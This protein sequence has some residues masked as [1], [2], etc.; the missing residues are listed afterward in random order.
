M[1]IEL[2]NI[3]VE[4]T[5]QCNLDCS[6]CHNIWKAGGEPEKFVSSYREAIKTLKKL[7]RWS[8]VKHITFTG[9]EPLLSE[10]FSEV[11]Q[12]ARIRKKEVTVVSN[13]N[14]PY[15]ESYQ[16]LLKLGVS[17]FKI[18]VHSS[19]SGEHDKMTNVEGSW[20]KA[21][22]T[23][24][25]ITAAG[26]SVLPVIV[27]TRHNISSV[28]STL[29]FISES[30]G[31]K[32]VMINRFNIGG[33][34]IAEMKNII[35]TMQELRSAYETANRVAGALNLKISSNVCTPFCV[36]NPADYPNI[37]FSSCSTDRSKLP[38][39][40]DL[41]G[42]IRLCNHS[43]LVAGNI[44]EK[45]LDEILNSEPATLWLK[46]TPE[47]CT[48]CSVYEN[49]LGGCRAAALQVGLTMDDADPIVSLTGLTSGA[50]MMKS[51]E[52]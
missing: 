4:T 26:G 36:V 6:Y 51:R 43:P 40:L 24:R 5:C 39:T 2:S 12:F 7:F 18:P 10:R 35:P 47:Y 25:E 33:K 41:T 19:F 31:L 45:S 34:G 13:G 28:E 22:T 15:P 17:L 37:A 20:A 52:S 50:E 32:Q 21:V 3:T 9:G 30:L 42:N 23:I 8:D 27:L 1:K 44:F 49:C 11:V 38:I 46:N 14:A 16:E 48:G 29:A